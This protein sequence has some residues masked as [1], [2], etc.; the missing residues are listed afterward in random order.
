VFGT[1]RWGV[2]VERI[3]EHL[4]SL[5]RRERG[6]LAVLAVLVVAGAVFWY[7]RSLPRPVTIQASEGNAGAGAVAVGSP[8][9]SLAVLFVHVTGRVRHAGVYQLH[10]GD[11]VIDAIRAAGGARKDADLRSINLAALV[12]DGEQILVWK[13]GPGGSV[14]TS[15]EGGGVPPGPGSPAQ[16]VNLNTATLDQLESLP[17]IGPALGQRII[18]YR[19]QH[20][21]FASVDD[22]VDVSGIGESRLED[23]R[24]LVTV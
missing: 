21:P 10:Q 12:T 13:K 15:G 18:D 9:P 24:P 6:G 1:K 14:V 16:P 19:T 5:R 8:S 22:L 2:I 23:L 20:G 17:G 4:G 7:V 3:E 11:R